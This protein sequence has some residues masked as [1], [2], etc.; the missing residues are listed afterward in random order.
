MT[1]DT[2]LATAPCKS[3]GADVAYEP[4]VVFG[5]DLAAGLGHICEGCTLAIANAAKA[6]EEAKRNHHAK[7]EMERVIPPLLRET[8]PS[9]PEFNV[10]AWQACRQ[11]SPASGQ[12][13]LIIGKTGLCKSRISA[14]LAGRMI[15]AG[16]RTEWCTA[17]AFQWAATREFDDDKAERGRARHWLSA[18]KNSPAL[19]FDDFG[20]GTF[21]GAVER[22][23]FDLIDHRHTHMLPTIISANTHPQDLLLAEAFTGDRGAPI[24][25]RILETCGNPIVLS[26]PKTA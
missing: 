17:N 11:W 20:K 8:N 21:S 24:V 10:K 3:C 26:S 22:H 5:H 13:L 1:T 15:R 23:L 19:V 16:I 2:Q 25:G 9:H 7:M 4:V 18:W 6:E 12:W 14:L